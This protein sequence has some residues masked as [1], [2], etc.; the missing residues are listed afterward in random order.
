MQRAMLRVQLIQLEQVVELALVLVWVSQ[1]PLVCFHSSCR[2]L[3]EH[4]AAMA[5]QAPKQST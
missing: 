3:S 4:L 2:S 5:A 1:S